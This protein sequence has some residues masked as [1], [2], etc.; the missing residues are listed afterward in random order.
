MSAP[1]IYFPP[2]SFSARFSSEA[3]TAFT[4][5]LTGW[6]LR[7]EVS[8]DFCSFC[9][10]K[11][12]YYLINVRVGKLEYV[13]H[14]RFSAFIVLFNELIVGPL[15]NEQIL[16]AFPKKTF[17]IFAATDEAFIQT[18]LAA[19]Q[20]YLDCALKLLNSKGDKSNYLQDFLEL[21]Q[22]FAK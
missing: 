5:E 12:I 14:R 6:T 3:L 17:M 4:C 2:S 15:R 1:L 18:R 22:L 11:T 21:P 10:T 7:E 20:E 19:L 9:N 16:V 8:E 13:V